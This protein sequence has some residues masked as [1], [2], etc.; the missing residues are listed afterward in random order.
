MGWVLYKM[1]KYKDAYKFQKRAVKAAPDE[2]EIVDHMKMILKK[3][4]K[5][6]SIE[7]VIKED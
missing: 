4:G 2:K 3:L 5:T 6:K 7:D 1:G